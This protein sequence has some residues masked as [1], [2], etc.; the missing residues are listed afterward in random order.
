MT[1]GGFGGTALVLVDPA[2]I[3]DV[4]SDISDAF[5]RSFGRIPASWT[6]RTDD[7]VRIDHLQP[8]PGD[9]A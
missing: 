5:E 3:E 1:G 7:G 8:G 4:R 2:R 6:A 9:D